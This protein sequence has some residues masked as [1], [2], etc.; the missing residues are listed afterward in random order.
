VSVDKGG[1]GS[2]AGEG[3]GDGDGDEDLDEDLDAHSL[4]RRSASASIEMRPRS[5]L[6]LTLLRPPSF[7]LPSPRL[8]PRLTSLN[9]GGR[10][11]EQ[12]CAE[13]HP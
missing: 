1:C 8:D 6:A 3:D 10:Q 7:S 11:P 4:M 12:G 5:P 9:G 13:R 2:G